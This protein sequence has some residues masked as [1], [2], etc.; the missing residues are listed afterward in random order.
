MQK[1]LSGRIT[2]RVQGV[3]FRAETCKLARRLGLTGWVRNCGNGDVE[4]LIA[5]PDAMLEQ[6]CHWLQQGP[7][8]ARVDTVSLE[9]CADPGLTGFDI[10]SDS[11]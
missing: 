6:M 11:R 1:A 2:G 8:H 9:S 5:G 3:C 7:G 4:L 10:L